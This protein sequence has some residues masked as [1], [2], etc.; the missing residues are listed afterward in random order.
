[1]PALIRVGLSGRRRLLFRDIRACFP[2]LGIVVGLLAYILH[3]LGVIGRFLFGLLGLV[4][5]VCL[6]FVIGLGGFAAAGFLGLTPV[7]FVGFGAGF[8]GLIVVGFV[9]RMLVALVIFGLVG[10]VVAGFVMVDLG[11]LFFGVR[12]LRAAVRNGGGLF[13]VVGRVL[14]RLELEPLSCRAVPLYIRPLPVVLVSPGRGVGGRG[15]L[16]AQQRYER[17]HFEQ[18]QSA[19]APAAHVCFGPHES[20]QSSP[21]HH[22]DPQETFPG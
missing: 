16:Q 6:V 12:I 8:V 3:L 14:I 5:L 18:R 1:M 9:G 17:E 2:R 15:P 4:E 13:A 11:V 21:I 19:P 7:G 22:P 10:F 20:S